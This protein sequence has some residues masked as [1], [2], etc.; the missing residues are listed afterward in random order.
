[1][2]RLA[3]FLSRNGHPHQRLDPAT[4]AS[5]K[6]LIERFDVEASELPIVLCRNG[7]LL[8]N[9]TEVELAACIGLVRP[10]DPARLYDVA[11]VGAGPA[12]LAAAVYGASEGLSVI[13]MDCRAFGGQA[14]ASACIENYLGFPTGINGLA[15]MARA[16]TQAQKFGAEMAIPDE[17]VH[18]ERIS[19]GDGA[20]FELRLAN[21]ERV[22]ARAVVIAA[23]PNTAASTSRTSRRSRARA[24]TT[25]PPRSRRSFVQD[26]RW[27]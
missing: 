19:D 17:V 4:D 15:L 1:M 26:R 7:R 8:R 16:F 23:A 2:L 3:G 12:G 14:G 5:A 6:A 27:R 9:P 11:I 20:R 21:D 10:V 18:L 24:S 22:R 25:G 13:V